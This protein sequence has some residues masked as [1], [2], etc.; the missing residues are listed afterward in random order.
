MT[1]MNK[2][3]NDIESGERLSFFKL[4]SDKG[5]KIEIPIIQRDYAQGRN[6]TLVVRETFLDALYGY[7]EENISNRDLDFV[8]G[9]INHVNGHSNFTPLDGQQRLTTLFLLHWYLAVA[10]DNMDILREALAVEE[11]EKEKKIYKSKFTYETRTSSKE[12]CDAL[13]SNEIKFSEL[14]KPDKDKGNSLSKTIQ[15]CGWFYLSWNNDPTIQSMLIMLDAI[16]SKFVDKKEFFNRLIDKDNPIITFLFL[17][18]KEFKLT[19]DLYIKMNARGMPL[20]TFENFKAKFEQHIGQLGWTKKDLRLLKYAREG[21]TE[22]LEKKF[23]PREYFSHKIDNDW[24]NLFWQYRNI[25]GKDNSL[26][27]EI[28]NF[29]RVIMANEYAG[30]KGSDQNLE[31]LIGTQVAR[32]KKGYTDKLTYHLYNKLCI[33]NN[34]SISYLID[35]LDCLENGNQEIKKHLNNEF[36]FNENETFKKVLRHDLTLPQRVQFHAYLKFL[37][38]NKTDLSGINQWMRVIHNLTENTRIDG[39]VEVSLAIVAIDKLI[40]YSQDILNYLKVYTNQVDFFH[41]RQ[42]QEEIIK[43]HLITKSKKWQEIIEKIEKH[44]YLKGQIAFILEFSGILTYFDQHSNCNWSSSEDNN[45]FLSFTKYADC[46]DATFSAIDP[47]KNRSSA[48]IDYLWERAVLSKGDYLIVTTANRKNLLSTTTNLRDY[49]W[50]RLLR[51]P[52]IGIQNDEIIYWKNRRDFVKN[53]FDDKD[54]DNKNLQA[55]LQ[56]IINTPINDWRKYFIG[57]PELIRYCEQGFIR[58]EDDYKITLYKQSQQNHRQREMYS[59]AFYLNYLNSVGDFT[60]F[61]TSDHEEVRSG[62]DDSFALLNNFCLNRINYSLKIYFDEISDSFPNH[63]QIR[64]E[65]SKGDKSIGE[66]VNSI[67]DILKKCNFE[68]YDENEERIGFWV[69]EKTDSDSSDT[70]K[71]LC[72]LL[73]EITIL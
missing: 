64:F 50:N 18:L 15:N 3:I 4:F 71:H 16:H 46:A 57:N 47:D 17:N 8:Y 49:S 48:S 60:P 66:Y 65:K 31:L 20:T 10:S 69:T 54:F 29:I 38:H 58:F 7:L 44:T 67:R 70:I 73:N 63:Y 52:P 24:A 30:K 25:N 68:W 6:S 13:M 34:S 72:K 53:V 9:S 22:K 23:S 56:N 32:K 21:N 43:A 41:G 1:L 42:V 62:D 36:Y 26:D 27:N 59:Y 39:A 37:I 14:L 5:Y 40:L 11:F 19:D 28:M 61:L 12:F 2:N 33:L 51:L 45:Y 35:A 55:S